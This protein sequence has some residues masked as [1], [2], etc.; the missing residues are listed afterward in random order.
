MHCVACGNAQM[1]RE[2]RDVLYTYKG[3]STTIPKVSGE[4]CPVCKESLHNA[5]ESEYL[6]AAMLAFTKEV[7][8][9]TK[10]QNPPTS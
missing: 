5:E 7:N 3:Q 4:Y 6:S 2:I 10:K 8:S 9:A 1:V